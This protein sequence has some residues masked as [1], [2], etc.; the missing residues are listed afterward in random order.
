MSCTQRL[1]VM[2]AAILPWTAITVPKT[3]GEVSFIQCDPFEL[4]QPTEMIGTA[5]EASSL[6]MT[7]V[8]GEYESIAFAMRANGEA[9][10][11]SMHVTDLTSSQGRIPQARADLWVVRWWDQVVWNSD[12]PRTVHLPEL[13]L[14]DGDVNLEGIS[15]PDLR[16]DG[17]PSVTIT[18]NAVVQIWLRVHIPVGTRPG[19]YRGNVIIEGTASR[20]EIP[21]QVTVL[22]IRLEPVIR[23]T[24]I[25]YDGGLT[26]DGAEDCRFV[27]EQ[28]FR[29]DLSEIGRA[30]F[31]AL[32]LWGDTAHELIAQINIAREMGFTRKL[33]LVLTGGVE[34]RLKVLQPVVKWAAENRV[35]GLCVYG[36][37]EPNHW[38]I[39]TSTRQAFRRYQEL[40]LSTV[41][42]IDR[43]FA[44]ALGDTLDIPVYDWKDWTN[45]HYM[46]QL[47][48]GELA[49]K[50][51]PRWYYFQSWLD[52]H[53]ALVRLQHG[54]LMHAVGLD[55]IMPYVY[56]A[57]QHHS[58]LFEEAHTKQKR[59]SMAYPSVQGSVPTVQW[60]AAQEGIDDIRLVEALERRLSLVRPQ[61]GSAADT[62]AAAREILQQIRTSIGPHFERHPEIRSGTIRDVR[63]RL[64]SAILA[65]DRAVIRPQESLVRVTQF[66]GF[67]NFGNGVP[68]MNLYCPDKERDS[69]RIKQG[70]VGFAR[71]TANWYNG[72][73][74]SVI[75]GGKDAVAKSLPEVQV[76]E[77]AATHA[78]VRAQWENDLAAFAVEIVARQD[79]DRL[80]LYYDGSP[81]DNSLD[82]RLVLTAYPNT[83]AGSAS[84]GQS[85]RQ[86]ALLTAARKISGSA[87]IALTADTAWAVLFDAYYD[88]ALRNQPIM[89]NYGPCALCFGEG[90]APAN[91]SVQLQNYAVL[92]H[93]P[94]GRGTVSESFVLYEF[95]EADNAEAFARVESEVAETTKL[96]NQ[97]DPARRSKESNSQ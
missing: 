49:R 29:T 63:E 82:T 3:S 46:H 62:A 73:F 88:R 36:A 96:L 60:Q 9:E 33:I 43:Q 67:L 26:K 79:D 31:N 95:P 27:V 77:E 19:S 89:Y 30:G 5:L 8:Q 53:P 54:L 72:G 41:C 20:N 56:H 71:C 55:G 25:F 74:L 76:I 92:V 57:S 91:W 11:V 34:E 51:Q 39:G 68:G 18:S 70:A 94:L 75:V 48:A 87:D 85:T 64:T 1:A 78:R 44:E 37:D 10:R 15:V 93:V 61:Q 28:R 80:Y 42:C 59:M 52:D 35:D 14:K 66:A 58:G 90:Q 6:Q 2:F 50:A 84:A 23:D 17:A 38:S 16:L 69:E 24:A 97:F 21:L 13:L 86:R 40:G 47:W 83:Y 22:P 45:Q 7:T 4:P 65:Y 81:R 32:T 12:P